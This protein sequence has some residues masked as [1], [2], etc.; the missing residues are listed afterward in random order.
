MLIVPVEWSWAQLKNV[1]TR[2]EGPSF[3][4]L[5]PEL[6]SILLNIT[7]RVRRVVMFLLDNDR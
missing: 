2:T 3:Q 5:E 4:R 7:N 6:V 1:E